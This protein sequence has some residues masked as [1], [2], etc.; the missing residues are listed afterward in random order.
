MRNDV[1]DIIFKEAEIV[2]SQ[3]REE[4]NKAIDELHTTRIKLENEI[5]QKVKKND[6]IEMKN[7]LINRLDTK[8][9]LVEVQNALNSL[10]TEVA[11]RLI[12]TKLELQNAMNGSQE[13]INHQLTK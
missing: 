1:K 10:Q 7:D 3:V 2:N 8:V 5:S 13:Y 11:N 9:E 6:L 4:I 12:N